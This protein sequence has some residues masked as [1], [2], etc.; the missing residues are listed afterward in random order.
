MTGHP[1]NIAFDGIDLTVMGENPEGLRKLPCGEG[2]CRVALMVDGE[3]G[4]ETL[5][6]QVRIKRGHLLGQEHAF[7]DN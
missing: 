2:I 4:N 6:H 5:I 1:I 3:V 7:V